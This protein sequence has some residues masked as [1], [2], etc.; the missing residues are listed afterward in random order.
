MMNRLMLL[1]IFGFGMISC[2]GDSDPE[3]P[4][5]VLPQNLVV[6]Y[7]IEGATSSD[8]EGDGSGNVTFKATASNTTSFRLEYDGNSQ[9]MPNGELTVTFELP[10][11]QAYDVKVTAFGAGNAS[12]N[13]SVSLD[14]KKEYEVPADI[15]SLLT[16]ND[17]QK[18]RIKSESAGHMGVGPLGANAPDYWTAAAFE[19]ENTSM[20]DDE[21]VFSTDK[22]FSHK[23]GGAVY[24]KAGP[25]E[26]DLGSSSEPKN[27]EDEIENYALA[28]YSG[29]WQYAPI[30][31]QDV[32][33]LSDNGFLGF[34]V[35]GT[36]AYTI[37]A[38]T[39]KE[40][41]LRTDGADDLSWFFIL[42][43]EEEAVIPADP[44]YTNLVWS[45]EFDADGAPD[46]SKWT[47]DIGDGSG[48]GEPG[49]GWGNNEEQYYTDRSDNVIVEDGVLKIIA[50]KEIFGGSPY[51]STRM[52][53]QGKYDFTYGRVDIK[54]KLP[55]GG[56]TWPALW[57]L[58]SNITTVS[59]PACGEIDIMEYVGNNPGKVQSALHTPSSSGNTVNYRK[60]DIENENDQ[61]HI[62]SMIWSEDQISF[63]LD[64]ERFYTYNPLIKD[65]SN[66]PF[67]KDQF[68]IMNIAM[69]G[70]LGGNIDAS[71]SEAEMVIDYVRIY[72]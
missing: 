35:G 23:T 3:T 26:S 52:K 61:Y 39:D 20:Y 13:K 69:G 37:L 66:W 27:D 43:T 6:T 1:L 5:V 8:P 28:D 16:N 9:P 25:L 40:L 11:V 2:G 67:D 70:V 47:Y 51:T 7:E 63:L 4:P 71:F 48:P 14:V 45:D 17:S 44:E 49:K 15:L 10:G 12:I 32:L 60:T 33:Y 53:T 29:T 68:L 30:R 36:H 31:G 46:D 58:G 62:Y 54:A 19:K 38:K 24:G 57:M 50:K 41:I 22:S 72:Q 56:G 65:T 21:F 64:G 55:S 59:W 42:T 18:W 34:Y